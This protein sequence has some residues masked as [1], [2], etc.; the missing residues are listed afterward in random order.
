MQQAP[1]IQ[2]A[3]SGVVPEQQGKKRS[4]PMTAE[5]GLKKV[6]RT[7]GWYNHNGNLQQPIIY[8]T[9]RD[10]LESVKPRDALKILKGLEENAATIRNP[11][12]W[13]RSAAEKL[14]PEADIKVRK[15]IAWYNMHGNLQGQITYKDVKGVLASLPAEEGLAILRSLES[16]ATTVRDPTAWLYTAAERKL[17]SWGMEAPSRSS[18]W[19]APARSWSGDGGTNSAGWK[20]SAGA[21]GMKGSVDKKLR[22]TIAWYNNCGGLQQ[23][24]IFDEVAVY[25]CQ[26]ELAEALKILKGLKDK[27]W[28]IKNPTS[29][30][31]KAAQKHLGLSI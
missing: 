17:G 3:G 18:S 22:T 24:I 9:V 1:L 16:K 23:P 6:K 30:I 19:S 20:G 28:S 10:Q 21:G 27:A 13:V 5:E 15:T 25:L 29:W 4:A 14:G 8:K 7:V 2:L 11:T 31:T 12:A 26:M